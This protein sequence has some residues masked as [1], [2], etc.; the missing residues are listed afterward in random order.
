VSGRSTSNPSIANNRHRRNHEP[1]ARPTATR[2]ATGQASPATGPHVRSKTSRITSRP[3]RFRACV[4]ALV[5]G[6]LH[7]A[8]QHRHRSNDPV[9]FVVT[10]L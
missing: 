8:F 10:S 5:V 2:P 4:I 1:R 7:A 9:T 3:N 6:T